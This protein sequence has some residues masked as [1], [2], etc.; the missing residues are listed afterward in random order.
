MKN[1]SPCILSVTGKNFLNHLTK[2]F[3]EGSVSCS[4]IDEEE[5]EESQY[6]F[7]LFYHSGTGEDEDTPEYEGS[8]YAP[9]EYFVLVFAF[10]AK[11]GE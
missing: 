6:P 2:M 7:K 5:S 1:L 10:D 9:E 11:E 8:E 4:G 3:F